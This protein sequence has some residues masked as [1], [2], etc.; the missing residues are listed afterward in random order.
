MAN[1][2][3]TIVLSYPVPA[4]REERYD[5]YGAANLEECVQI[6]FDNDLA[7]FILES[8]VLEMQVTGV[9]V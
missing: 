2:E 9:S 5:I 7:A 8:T 3:V 1:V 6:D 4:D